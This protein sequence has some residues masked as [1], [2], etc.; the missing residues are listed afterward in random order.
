MSDSIEYSLD[1]DLQALESKL[2]SLTPRA[3]PHDAIRRAKQVVAKDDQ[4]SSLSEKHSEVTM[5][6]PEDLGN[7]DELEGHLNQLSPAAMPDD[8]LSRMSQAMDG[9]H[10]HVEEVDKVLPFTPNKQRVPK[11]F[12][13]GMLSAAAA[14]AL[15]GAVTALV[16]PQFSTSQSNSY[17]QSHPSAPT[18]GIV[19]PLSSNTGPSNT[20]A[21]S[22]PRKASE[23]LSHQVTRT[24]DSGVILSDDNQPLRCIRVDYID[25][26]KGVDDSGRDVEIKTPGID[27]ILIPVQTD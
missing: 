12:N 1:E 9:W 2:A 20:G 16:M 4:P 23:G 8:L 21:P 10:E 15:L 18:S 22:H 27:Y 25:Q 17:A 26:V 19:T 24:T 7:L 3:I 5:T 14:V 13:K 11:V 6:S